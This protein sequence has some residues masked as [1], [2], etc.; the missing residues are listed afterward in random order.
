MRCKICDKEVSAVWNS[1]YNEW[2]I[3]NECKQRGRDPATESIDN[4]NGEVMPPL[5]WDYSKGPRPA[6]LDMTDA[7]ILA[8]LYRR[9]GLGS[10]DIKEIPM[11]IFDEKGDN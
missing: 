5:R 7:E 4:D 10:L 6:C 2:D 9:L 8:S 11:D 1:R 3:C